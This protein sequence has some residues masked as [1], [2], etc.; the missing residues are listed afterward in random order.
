MIYC[1]KSSENVLDVL[2]TVLKEEEICG[3]PTGDLGLLRLTVSYQT[4]H[5]AFLQGSFSPVP[6]FP[7]LAAQNGKLGK[8]RGRVGVMDGGPG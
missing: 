5:R 8:G 1:P 4:M 6:C 3:I 2:C 7:C